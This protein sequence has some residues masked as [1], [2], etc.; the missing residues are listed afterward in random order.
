MKNA[1]LAEAKGMKQAFA[2]ADLNG[3]ATTGARIGL[4]NG[5]RVA[6]VVDMGSSTG[7]SVNFTLRQ[8]DAASSGNSK[9]LEVANPYYHKVDGD[10]KFTKIEPSTESASYDL[11]SLFAA[12][13]GLVVFEVVE[14]QLDTD[15][16]FAWFSLDVGDPGAAKV[17]A[18]A[19]VM[20]ADKE[21][22]YELDL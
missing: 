19:Y 15:N 3:G 22:A 10:T 2:P 21:P 8:H 4:K 14:D 9:D 20:E 16:G 1:Y 17:F 13:G 7:A 12:D 5:S 11:S 6:V 18:A